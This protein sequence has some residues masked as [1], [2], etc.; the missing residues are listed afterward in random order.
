MLFRSSV[1]RPTGG[2]EAEARQRSKQLWKRLEEVKRLQGELVGEVE[3]LRRFGD[4]EEVTSASE[5]RIPQDIR[6]SKLQQVQGL[7]SRETA[8]VEAVTA[9]LERLQANM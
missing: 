8:L 2:E 7:L 9:R 4:V 3:S 1:S 5:L 6:R